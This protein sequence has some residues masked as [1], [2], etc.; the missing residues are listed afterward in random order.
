MQQLDQQDAHFKEGDFGAGLIAGVTEVERVLK[1]NSD[2]VS[3][4]TKEATWF[5]VGWIV[6]DC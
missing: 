6:I 3:E 1:G 2:L 5:I 4:D